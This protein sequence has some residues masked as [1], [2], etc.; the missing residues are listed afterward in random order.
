MKF[1]CPHCGQELEASEEWA[2]QT[3][4]CPTCGESIVAPTLPVELPVQSPPA[5]VVRRSAVPAS[6]NRPPSSRRKI[7][8]SFSTRPAGSPK[9]SGGGS[10]IKILFWLVIL[11]IVGGF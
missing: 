8:S 10:F 7:P 5:P 4:D 9:G 6:T 3:F 2:G 1:R 11:L